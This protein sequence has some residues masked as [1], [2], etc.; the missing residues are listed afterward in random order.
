MSRGNGH[1]LEQMRFLL[2]IRKQEL[3]R[4]GSGAL[5]QVVQ[6]GCGV[7]S[8]KIFSSCLD[9]GLGILLRVELLEQG[10]DMMASRGPFQSQD[11]VK[12]PWPAKCHLYTTAKLLIINW[13]ADSV[14]PAIHTY[15]SIQFESLMTSSQFTFKP[16]IGKFHYAF[17][18]HF[19]TL[20]SAQTTGDRISYHLRGKTTGGQLVLQAKS[21]PI[22]EKYCGYLHN[23]IHR[24]TESSATSRIRG[25]AHVG[26]RYR[27]KQQ[28][29]LL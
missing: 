23:A 5:A 3:F 19:L 24:C 29:L 17:I 8:V 25:R 18:S 4:A 7:S 20:C 21:K 14:I 6:Q 15:F 11:S 13:A 27:N 16:H 9:M 22:Q 26:E 1:K 10:L 2:T 12:V 28:S